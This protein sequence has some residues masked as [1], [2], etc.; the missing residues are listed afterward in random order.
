MGGETC[1]HCRPNQPPAE[2]QGLH[3]NAL[4]ALNRHADNHNQTTSVKK[5]HLRARVKYDKIP[6]VTPPTGEVGLTSTNR[7]RVSIFRREYQ[8]ARHSRIRTRPRSRSGKSPTKVPRK[9]MK[10]GARN[11]LFQAL[12]AVVFYAP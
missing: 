12:S 11:F 9:P 2:R 4:A 1:P 10:I 7:F 3:Y 6:A 8:R 5:P